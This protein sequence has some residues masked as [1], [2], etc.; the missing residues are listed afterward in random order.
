MIAGDKAPDFT[1]FD[2]TGRPRTLS[3]FLSDGPVVLFFF[4]LASSP[5]CTAQ[6]CHFRDLSDEFAKVGAHRVGISTDAVDK[7]AHFAQQRS[8]DYPLLSDADGVVSELFGVRR[9]RLAKLHRSVVARDE[10][11]RGQHSR[12]RGL[13]ARLLPVRRTTF[14]IDTDRTILKVVSSELRASVHADQALWFLQNRNAAHGSSQSEGTVEPIGEWFTK[15]EAVDEPSLVRPYALKAGGTDCGAEL[16]LET[17]VE[18]LNTTA[19]PPRWSRN[20][21]RGQIL[22][23]CRQSPSVAEIA[24]RLSLPVGATRFLVDDLVTQGYLRVHAP[25]NDSMTIDERRELIRRT[26]RGLRALER[27][28][29]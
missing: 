14:I 29:D 10:A 28:A 19:K 20:D 12:R 9:G 23:C 26:L 15:P 8:F 7:Q 27:S 2:H 6:A 13:L 5:I 16:A 4:P 18:A 17:P 1:L 3:T 25:L 22:T 24:A 11:R 21:V